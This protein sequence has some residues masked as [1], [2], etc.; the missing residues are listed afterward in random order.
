M[1]FTTVLVA[2][3]AAAPLTVQAY[4]HKSGERSFSESDTKADLPGVCRD[5]FASRN[6][7]R[8]ETISHCYTAPGV[9]DKHWI[10]S[11][12]R[13]GD[14]SWVSQGDCVKWLSAEVDNC[15]HGGYSTRAGFIFRYLFPPISRCA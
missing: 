14:S 15:D 7:A 13:K 3:L 10:F 6:Y 2:L 1:Q 4:C 11:V 9:P 5:K 12:Q 8:S